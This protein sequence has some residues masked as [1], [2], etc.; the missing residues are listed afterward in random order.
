MLALG[1]C[2][3]RRQ[4]H[5]ENGTHRLCS[6]APPYPPATRHVAV[7]AREGSA[8]ASHAPTMPCS[9]FAASGAALALDVATPIRIEEIKEDADLAWQALHHAELGRATSKLCL[10]DL[11]IVVEVPSAE[12]CRG[13]RRNESSVTQRRRYR[14]GTRDEAISALRR[15]RRPRGPPVFRSPTAE[16]HTTKRVG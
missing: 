2:H 4:A 16:E 15:P 1:A 10:G 12:E 14:V 7:L 5:E 3:L 13:R 6:A 9:C 8:Q 11:A